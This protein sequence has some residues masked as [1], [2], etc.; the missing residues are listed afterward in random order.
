MAK[1]RIV[2]ETMYNKDGNEL[3]TKYIVQK[4]LFGFLF[5]YDPFDDGY[6]SNGERETYKEAKELLESLLNKKVHEVVDEI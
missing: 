5:W 1:Y 3:S 6:W 4:R 2:K